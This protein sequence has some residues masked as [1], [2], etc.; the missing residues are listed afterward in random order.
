MGTDIDI[1]EQSNLKTSKPLT[2]VQSPFGIGSMSE[3][4]IELLS[5]MNVGSESPTNDVCQCYMFP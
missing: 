3:Q 2:N 1:S 4:T 5:K